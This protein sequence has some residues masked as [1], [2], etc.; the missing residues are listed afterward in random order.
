MTA[1][2]GDIVVFRSSSALQK[3]FSDL[4]HSQS[5]T[6]SGQQDFVI[7]APSSGREAAEL[8]NVMGYFVNTLPLRL[9]GKS[10]EMKISRVS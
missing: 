6:L 9:G 4:C 1:T 7:G 3:A 10:Q 8:Q 2:K 5:A